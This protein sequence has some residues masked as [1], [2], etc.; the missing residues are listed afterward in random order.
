MARCDTASG[1]VRWQ[2]GSKAERSNARPNLKHKE[3]KD[4]NLMTGAE[5]QNHLVKELTEA[6]RKST[7]YLNG[8]RAHYGD[9][10]KLAQDWAKYPN[11]QVRPCPCPCPSTLL[12]EESTDPR[13]SPRPSLH[14]TTLTT[15]SSAHTSVPCSS[16]TAASSLALSGIGPR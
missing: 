10:I 2:Q 7:Q 16:S 3:S 8:C 5:V 12:F 4:A 6:Y 1:R 15:S 13:T 14:R 11:I 9:R